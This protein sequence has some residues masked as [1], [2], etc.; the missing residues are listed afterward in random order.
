MMELAEPKLV[1]PLIAVPMQRVRHYVAFWIREK[2]HR[3]RIEA[4][5]SYHLPLLKA[6]GAMRWRRVKGPIV[7]LIAALLD[8][9]WSPT[10]ST[11]WT[12]SNCEVW[13]LDDAAFA[14]APFQADFHD[15]RARHAWR[16]AST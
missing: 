13:Q 16:S 8:L 15:A 2:A 6:M 7:A 4:S 1:D 3:A 12:D 11:R 14:V 5:W 9:G 10:T